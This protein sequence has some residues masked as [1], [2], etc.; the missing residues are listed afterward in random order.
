MLERLATR[1]Y[2]IAASASTASDDNTRP[3]GA[4]ISTGLISGVERS[5]SEEFSFALAVVLTP[6]V[7]ALE[8][9][10]LHKVTGSFHPDTVTPG[11]IG[12]VFAFVA[13]LGALKWLSS[14]LE[15]GRWRYFG[16]YCLVAA[17]GVATMA[18][19]GY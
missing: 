6:P 18:A 8:M 3:S 4:T 13:G 19:L 1:D 2:S 11:L 17:A 9:H 16:Y 10:R 5:L 15:N 7:I 14:W 12:M